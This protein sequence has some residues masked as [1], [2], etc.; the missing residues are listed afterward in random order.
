MREERQEEG[1]WKEGEWD[2]LKGGKLGR[3]L[4]PRVLLFLALGPTRYF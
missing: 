2:D 3:S 1:L 4:D